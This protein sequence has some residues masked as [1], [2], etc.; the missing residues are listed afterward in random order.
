MIDDQAKY[1]LTEQDIN[2]AK[3]KA[4]DRLNSLNKT[5]DIIGMQV[6][7][8]LGLNSGIIFYPL[9]SD[10][11]WGFTDMKGTNDNHTEKAFVVLNSSISVDCQI[12]AAAHELYHIWYERVEDIITGSDLDYSDNNRTEQMASRF[13]AEFLVNEDLLKN[14]VKS[15]VKDPNQIATKDILKLAELFVVPYKTMVRRLLETG[16]LDP[17][18]QADYL[19]KTEK[20]IEAERKRY[21][22]SVVKADDRI[23]IANHTELAVEAYEKGLITYERLEHLLKKSNLAP[24]DVGIKKDPDYQ[25]PSDDELNDIMGE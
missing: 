12:F 14:E 8:I 24:E 19:D 9:G 16:I 5:N 7:S 18:S 1:V 20:E 15:Y 2:E 13:A 17:E 3:S 6:F 11:P 10:A 25:F 23:A 4:L 21:A 22:I